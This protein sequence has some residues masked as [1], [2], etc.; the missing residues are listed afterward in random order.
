[1]AKD[2]KLSKKQKNCISFQPKGSLL[3]R[4]IP[5]SGKTT[6]LLER[7]SFLQEF[8]QASSVIFLTYSR[9]L[10]RFVRQLSLKTHDSP[11]EVMT[12]HS[13]ASALLRDLG[14]SKLTYVDDQADVVRHAFNIINKN[15]TNV[16]LPKI[17]VN[18]NKQKQAINK[19]LIEEFSWIKAQGIKNR[20]EYLNIKRI[21]RSN[22]IRVTSDHRHSIYDVFEKYQQLLK[23]FYRR[24]DFDDI[25][26]ILNE[27]LNLIPEDRMPDHILIDE[28]QDLSPMQLK[29]MALLAKK[30]FTIGADK[31]QQ[32]YR[33]NFSWKD[34]GID[35]Q[36]ARS[37][38][39]NETFRSTVEIISLANSLQKND[40]QLIKQEDY[41]QA[42]VPN[43]KGPMPELFK[44]N[45][46]IEEVEVAIQV[47]QK[48]RSRFPDHTIGIIGYSAK[49]LKKFAEELEI[50]KIPYTLVKEDE[51]DI[52]APGVKLVNY[53]SAKGLEFD[54]AV[55][56]GLKEGV[57][58]S[59]HI[60]PGEEE[61]DF[62]TRERRK[63]YVAM[64]RAKLTLTI[65]A[66]RKYSR[67]IEEL[68]SQLFNEN[69]IKF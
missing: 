25:A 60:L 54:H 66:P 35:I 29:V 57:M 42:A 17:E 40:H 26:I 12:F 53:Y 34:L 39:L 59:P 10:A 11:V 64:T 2:I 22:T 30:S 7:A 24:I 36:G 37:K 50:E 5:G 18:E 68:D 8:D 44:L 4:G 63:L 48:I 67:F 32:I 51:A 45:N 62:I 1:M 21:G 9:T 38:F 47:V 69:K 49:Y 33:R 43:N 19:F 55:V 14:I 52:L 6:I 28:A 65:L 23:N 41:I 46:R 16:N 31:G 61:E 56:T 3:V 58:P 13:W 20:E 27:N 15:N